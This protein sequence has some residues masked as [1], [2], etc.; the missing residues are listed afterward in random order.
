MKSLVINPTHNLQEIET[1]K[2]VATGNRVIIKTKYSAVCGSDNGIWKKYAGAVMGH[3]FSGYVDDP[4]AFPVKRGARVCAPEFNPCGRCEFCKAGQEQLCEQMVTESP[5]VSIPGALGEYFSVRGDMLFEIPED[6]PMEL[7][8]IAEPVA[9]SLHGVRLAGV[10]ANDKVLLWG[11]G[12]IALY[13]A[14]C[15]KLSGAAEVYLVGRGQGRVD[16]V[17]EHFD[18][19]DKCFSIKDEHFEEQLR[20][21]MPRCGFPRAIDCMGL[22]NYDQLVSFVKPGA[23][24]VLLGQHSD[25]TGFTV[26]PFTSKE[27]ILR[28]SMFF[29]YKDYSDAVDMIFSNCELFLSTITKYVPHTAQAV[30]AAFVSL[31]DS[32]ANNECKVVVEY[33]D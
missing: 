28:S 12:P 27:I 17:N 4:G 24:I 10:S 1:D 19:V 2:P 18:F 25:T 23:T 5:G 6:A 14:A 21:V 33:E 16:Y 8:A 13:A 31:F 22:E 9:V 7:G 3:E 32:G 15:A 29:T 26:L 11:N 30:Q 20:A